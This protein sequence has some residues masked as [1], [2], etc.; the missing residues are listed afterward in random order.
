[1][2][3][4]WARLA[5]SAT[6]VKLLRKASVDGGLA[7]AGAGTGMAGILVGDCCC[8]VAIDD[9]DL[10]F[11][12]D[13]TGAFMFATGMTLVVWQRVELKVEGVGEAGDEPEEESC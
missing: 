1:M 9:P 3:A 2:T 5:A 11:M 4:T 10:V 7:W 12:C 13:A 8:D 6:K